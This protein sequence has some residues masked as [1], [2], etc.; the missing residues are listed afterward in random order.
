MCAIRLADLNGVCR[1]YART[2]G[3]IKRACSRSFSEPEGARQEFRSAHYRPNASSARCEW[4]AKRR[5]ST[6]AAATG[7]SRGLCRVSVSDWFNWQSMHSQTSLP[8]CNWHS[9]NTQYQ[10]HI[11]TVH[12]VVLHIWIRSKALSMH[13]TVQP[14]LCSAIIR[15]DWMVCLCRYGDLLSCLAQQQHILL[16]L[17]RLPGTSGSPHGYVATNPLQTTILERG[18]RMFVLSCHDVFENSVTI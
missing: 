6:S 2:S 17:Y 5:S 4:W 11:Y 9:I 15:Q 1:D 3:S 12:S 13:R 8:A 14:I 10:A 16:G 18:D 7:N